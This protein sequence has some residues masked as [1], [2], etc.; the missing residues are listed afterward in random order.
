MIYP[1]SV[2]YKLFPL[3]INI[4]VDVYIHIFTH[5]ILMSFDLCIGPGNQQHRPVK[6]IPQSRYRIFERNFF[7][8]K[9]SLKA[10]T[11][12]ISFRPSQVLY[13]EDTKQ[14]SYK[15]NHTIIHHT[16]IQ[17]TKINGFIAVG[18][19]IHIYLQGTFMTVYCFS[20][21]HLVTALRNNFKDKITGK[22]L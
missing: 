20:C 9:Q 13:M 19:C 1:S 4:N 5:I 8:F 17:H 10:S 2:L 16:K 22:G 7:T 3:E 14:S 12:L 21:K 18:V 6:P 11:K 15:N